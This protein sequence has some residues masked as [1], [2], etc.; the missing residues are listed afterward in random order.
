M[1]VSVSTLDGYF[2]ERYGEVSRAVPNWA[3]LQRNLPFQQAKRLGDSYHFP[4]V[5][6]RSHGTTFNGSQAGTAFTLN[7]AKSLVSRDAQVSGTEFVVQEDIAYGVL[8]RAR[9]AGEAA[10]GSALDEVVLGMRDT[11]A[12]YC[13]MASLYGGTNIGAVDGAPVVAGTTATCTIADAAWAPGLW[14]GMEGACVDVFDATLTTKRNTVGDL[15]VSTIDADAK[16]VDLTGDAADVGAIA[17]TDVIVPKGANGEWYSGLDQIITNTGTL[18]NIDASTYN[19]WRGNTYATGGGKLTLSKVQAGLTSAVVRGLMDDV[20]CYVSVYSWTD[21]NNDLA[22]LRRYPNDTRGEFQQGTNNIVFH[23]ANGG[24]ITLIPHPMVKAG[25]A[26]IVPKN[27]VMRIGSTDATFRLPGVDGQQ[28]NF[29]Q[30]LESSAAVRL[31][32]YW[33]QALIATKPAKL[34]KLT[35]IEPESD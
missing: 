18:F 29:F 16:T 28:E 3:V 4:V 33:D 35:G 10:F 20:D 1:S 6:R 14:T 19:L 15:E 21:L 12:F 30:E 23:G 5:L 24:S 34:V 27:N 25:E 22:A 32:C 31:R 13:E 9:E 2:K 17:D 26:F 11:A 7:P 8:S